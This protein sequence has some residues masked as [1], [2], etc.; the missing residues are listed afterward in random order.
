MVAPPLAVDSACALGAVTM[1]PLAEPDSAPSEP[2]YVRTDNNRAEAAPPSV[3]ACCHLLLVVRLCKFPPHLAA[4]PVHVTQPGSCRGK[5]RRVKE[6][7]RISMRNL[8]L[9]FL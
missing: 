1:I 7:Q 3:G 8:G 9:E 2:R 5:L 4:A 6:N